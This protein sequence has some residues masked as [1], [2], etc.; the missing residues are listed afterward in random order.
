MVKLIFIKRFLLL[1]YFAFPG[2]LAHHALEIRVDA[3][4]FHEVPERDAAEL[5]GVVPVEIKPVYV[6]AESLILAHARVVEVQRGDLS[7]R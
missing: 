4:I 1:I 3:G 7:T 5:V 2:S 6:L